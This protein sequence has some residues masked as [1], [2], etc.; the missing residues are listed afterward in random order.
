MWNTNRVVV[1]VVNYVDI[2]FFNYDYDYY[3]LLMMLNGFRT[4]VQPSSCRYGHF[5]GINRKVQLTYL[6]NGQL[7]A[8]SEE[9]GREDSHSHSAIRLRW[10]IF[11]ANR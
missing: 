4:N 10:L 3:Y 11:I 2:V 6:P 8:S 9:E 5:S 7:K 1:V